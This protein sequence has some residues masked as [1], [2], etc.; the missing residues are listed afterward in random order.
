MK[1]IILKI[2]KIDLIGLF[3]G[4]NGSRGF[5]DLM[6]S[7]ALLHVDMYITFKWINIAAAN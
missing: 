7:G 4:V 1:L 5:I 6:I 2:N 3:V